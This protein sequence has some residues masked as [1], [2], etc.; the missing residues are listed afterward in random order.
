M[1][2]IAGLT[3]EETR[4]AAPGLVFDLYFLRRQYDDQL[5]GIKRKRKEAAYD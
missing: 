3:L 5:H 4:A 1:G 2:L